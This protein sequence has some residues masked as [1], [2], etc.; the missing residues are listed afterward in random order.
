MVRG[1]STLLSVALG[2]IMKDL[3]SVGVQ[4]APSVRAKLT[5]GR[6]PHRPSPFQPI[7]IQCATKMELALRTPCRARR[8][9]Y[10]RHTFACDRCGN[11]Q[12]YTMGTSRARLTEIWGN[13]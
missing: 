1:R 11:K 7:C 12:T 5:L 8:H 6:R 2:S 9:S 13:S 10:E 3:E 4:S